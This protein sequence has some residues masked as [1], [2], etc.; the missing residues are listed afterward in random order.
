MF[1]ETHIE[2]RSFHVRIHKEH[3][4]AS[5][6]YWRNCMNQ[7][8]GW[9]W[10]HIGPSWT[11]Q[12]NMKASWHKV[13]KMFLPLIHCQLHN[14]HPKLCITWN[15]NSRE[16]HQ[17]WWS[18]F[19]PIAHMIQYHNSQSP[20]CWSN[21]HLL[22]SSGGNQIGH[23]A[24][25]NSIHNNPTYKLYLRCLW[26]KMPRHHRNNYYSWWDGKQKMLFPW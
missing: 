22:E 13:Q 25:N 26:Y 16:Q 17:C 12:Q 5:Q 14:R 3:R 10:C 4:T 9:D 20:L 24:Q 2:K 18:K 1:R 23:N 15:S 8:L 19:R 11:N 6:N 7:H 21:D